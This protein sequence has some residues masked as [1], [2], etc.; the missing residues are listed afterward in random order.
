MESLYKLWLG[1][2][3]LFILHL[4]RSPLNSFNNI[5]ALKTRGTDRGDDDDVFSS[6]NTSELM[7]L[8]MNDLGPDQY[9]LNAPDD[10]GEKQYQRYMFAKTNEDI[11][12]AAINESGLEDTRNQ[13]SYYAQM[14]MLAKRLYQRPE[15]YTGLYDKPAN[16]KRISAAMQSI[17]LMMDR[18]IFESQLR[19]E[20]IMSM[21]LELKVAEEQQNIENA[22]GLLKERGN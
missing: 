6:V 16:V 7:Y 20:A 17:K 18:D 2:W 21:I 12:E 4:S 15:F 9:P 19:S 10:F 5:V 1:W 14:E 3:Q 22:L 13:I 8:I 11:D